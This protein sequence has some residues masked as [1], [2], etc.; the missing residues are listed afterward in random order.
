MG[1]TRISMSFKAHSLAVSI[2]CDTYTAPNTASRAVE[3]GRLSARTLSAP[4]PMSMYALNPA[5]SP[6]SFSRAFRVSAFTRRSIVPRGLCAPVFH[7]RSRQT[8]S[9]T[10]SPSQASLT[11]DTADPP[12]SLTEPWVRLWSKRSSVAGSP[13]RAANSE[14]G[15]RRMMS[16]A[17]VSTR[18]P[19]WPGKEASRTWSA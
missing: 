19:R 11:F 7:S 14:A 1:G 12:R 8:S 13:R 3:T 6:R 10:A 5:A 2:P 16:E 4:G 17:K 15:R 18:M 9:R